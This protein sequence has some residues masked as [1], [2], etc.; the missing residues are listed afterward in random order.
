MK[1]K[2]LCRTH[3]Y[4]LWPYV[5][6][7][8]TFFETKNPKLFETLPLNVGGSLLFVKSVYF[9]GAAFAFLMWVLR[10]LTGLP[11]GNKFCN[12]HEIC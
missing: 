2:Q 10:D 8:F 3:I 12:V 7:T 11:V 4:H 5:T 1:V 6:F 9:N